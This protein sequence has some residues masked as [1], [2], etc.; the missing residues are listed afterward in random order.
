MNRLECSRR[1]A[2]LAY[3]LKETGQE[4]VLQAIVAGTQMTMVNFAE[5]A[6]KYA[7]NGASEAQIRALR[8]K[9]PFPLRSVDEEI[10]T[11][12]GAIAIETKR[13]GLSLG[14][15]CCLA[16]A[17]VNSVPAITADRA[18]AD[19]ANVLGVEIQLIR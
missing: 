11:V 19:L 14:D 2:L 8:D 15:R 4:K 7:L 13:K 6:A 3:F 10:A 16:F 12:S 1:P 5:V 18:W 9:L 17:K